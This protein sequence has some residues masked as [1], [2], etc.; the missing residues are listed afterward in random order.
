VSI[1]NIDMQCSFCLY[2]Y[3]LACLQTENTHFL[4]QYFN[5]HDIYSA[6]TKSIV[7]D[8]VAARLLLTKRG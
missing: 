2:A 4:H 3:P 6:P 5:K 1:N 7:V 8:F